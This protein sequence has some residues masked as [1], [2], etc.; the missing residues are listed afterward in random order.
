MRS[1]ILGV[2]GRSLRLYPLK[3]HAFVF[4]SN[5][6][7][8]LVTVRDSLQLAQFMN[9][10]NSNLAREAGRLHDWREKFW[11]RRYQAI[12]VSEEESAQVN[13]IRYLLS[14]GCKEGLVARPGQWPGAHSVKALVSGQV[15]E[16]RW[17]DRTKECLA[18]A[19]RGRSR[20]VKVEEL[21]T[22]KLDPLPC[23]K[24]LARDRYRR[25]ISDL[26][27]EIEEETAARHSREGTRPLGVKAVVTQDPHARPERIKRTWRPAFHAASKQ[28]RRNLVDAYG[29]FVKIYLAAAE[30]RRNGNYRA[31]FPEGSFPPRPPFVERRASLAPG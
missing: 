25:A 7:H 17:I 4:M 30:S 13:R 22:V 27:H 5:H 26:V 12:V 29:W 11:G 31:R 1:L 23:W 21:E 14:H 10:L 8:L 3:L 9:Y 18:R 15:L 2:L 6:Y 19:R 20:R 24:S 16:G 28:A